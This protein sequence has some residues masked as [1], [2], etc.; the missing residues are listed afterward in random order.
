MNRFFG[1]LQSGPQ[2]GIIRRV[3]DVSL[4]KAFLV[5]YSVTGFKRALALDTIGKMRVADLWLEHP[6][7]RVWS[8]AT[9]DP[10]SSDPKFFHALRAP[11][12]LRQQPQ[13]QRGCLVKKRKTDDLSD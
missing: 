1:F 13:A 8:A 12:F 10:T 5:R 4:K 11:P 3:F 7:K 6:E 9:C 2:S